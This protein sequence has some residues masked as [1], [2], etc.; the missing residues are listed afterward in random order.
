MFYSLKKFFF[1]KPLDPLNPKIR[2]NIALITLL[3]W[4]G[5]GADPLSS[6]CY[7]PEEA[8]IA[9]GAN[10]ELAFFIA[11]ISIVTIFII[12]FG[13][14]QV[15]ALF[16]NGGGG[17]QV[18][19]K[20]LHPFLGL[21][22]GTA[23]I[24][25]YALTI[26]ISIASGTDAVFSFLPLKIAPFKL[27]VENVSVILL[28]A[29]NL[30]GIKEAVQFLLP[31][32]LGF[33]VTHVVLIIYGV[34]A[35][36]EG[37]S[38]V[39]PHALETT[40]K[41]ANSLGWV[42]TIGLILHAYSLG[43]GT[44]T[45]LEAVSN[46]VQRL[47]E[48]RVKTGK[49]TMLC[50]AFSLSFMA[51]GIILLYLLWQVQP[52]PGMTL[53]AVVFE[54]ILGPS[55][56]GHLLLLIILLLEAGLLFVA[57]NAGFASG[58]NVLASMALDNLVPNRFRHLSNRLV[59]QNGLF[60]Y[61]FMALGILFLTM[62]RVSILVVLYSIN[63][64]ITFSLSLLGISI[65]WLKHKKRKNW[66]WHFLLS[67]FACLITTS[68]LCIVLFYKFKAGAWATLFITALLVFVCIF[69][70]LHYQ[71]VA[72]EL[73]KL[74]RLLEQPLDQTSVEYLA[75]YA[76]NPQLP[77]AAIFVNNLSV[78]MHT[79]L[80]ILRLFPGQFKNFVFLSAGAVD[81]ASFQGEQELE[82]MQGKVNHQLDYFV[83]Y[84][85][86][87]QI[88]AESYSA[89][90]T[91]TMEQLKEL[92]DIV[93]NKYP[94]VIFFATQLIFRHETLVTKFLHNQTPLLLQHYLHLHG[95][96]LMIMPMRI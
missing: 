52:K 21:I 61:G 22:A 91:D 35:H 46:N 6:S 83:K 51:G 59:V 53:N 1:G 20:L 85:R 66:I 29:L 55:K 42:A 26:A 36:A 16:P 72:K 27:L 57:A 18:A 45:G 65:Y 50:M 30:R 17:Y 5:L 7:G 41:L 28:L 19:S 25:D 93:Q 54:A 12:S 23:L 74:D 13:Y 77:T 80:S 82:A 62:G 37:L 31:V 40:H 67:S 88:P 24:V 63:V 3:A 60:F 76:I 39:V 2:Q 32:F 75:P 78:G 15:I 14:N 8:Y 58:P 11:I 84:C 73:A 43:A 34:F 71:Y 38:V 4:V 56:I 95:R 48:P 86:Q 96:E 70:R 89:F 81:A 94:H 47:A 69:I 92:S 49:R 68:I 10:P 64:F 90:G 44:Y 79:L 9:L 33:V 87:Y